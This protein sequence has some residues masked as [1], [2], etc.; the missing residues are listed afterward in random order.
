MFGSYS[1]EKI[2]A[3][4][5]IFLFAVCGVLLAREE[6]SG[7]PD[8]TVEAS[9]CAAKK[10]D[11]V[12]LAED[13]A[14]A[15]RIVEVTPGRVLLGN[16]LCIAVAGVAPQPQLDA[17]TSDLA[18]KRDAVSRASRRFSDARTAAAQKLA[19]ENAASAA[20]RPKAQQARQA[21]DK[22]MS[23]EEQKHRQA[24]ADL[25]M[26]QSAAQKGLAPVKLTL[27]LAGRRAGS[28]SAPARAISEIQ[29]LS[30]DL[31]PA[32][33]G[34][35]DTGKFWRAVFA[36]PTHSA[37]PGFWDERFRRLPVGLSRLEGDR[38]ETTV[39]PAIDMLIYRMSLVMLG[40]AGALCLIG[41]LALLARSTAL[42]RD[43]PGKY[44]GGELLAP[45]SLARVQLA[46]WA[47]LV[48]F[49]F[50]FIWLVLGQ[51]NGILNESI[52]VLLGISATTGL[53]ATQM[54]RR[55]AAPPGAAGAPV[56]AAETPASQGFLRDILHDGA[57]P[58]LPRIQMVAWTV[59]L[60]VIFAWNVATGFV[61]YDFD[62]YLLIMIG[63]AGSSYVAFKP[64]ESPSA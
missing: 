6:L 42:L 12:L 23:A 30:F 37:G 10:S 53:V 26:A 32:S 7:R 17:L 45:Y 51:A 48:F 24:V 3:A 43:F 40:G 49:G 8:Y 35:D 33:D 59:L 36:G 22:E 46:L 60:A 29:H 1:R 54:P 55:A 28:I 18:E 2:L 47:V 27:F 5:G 64:V 56:P 13:R 52:L 41:A 16:S 14:G 50:V 34:R 20:D 58:A 39:Q 15:L 57:G 9:T 44:P 62:T 4:A 25:E 63:I 61:F 21:A 31:R 38:P 11:A 19:D